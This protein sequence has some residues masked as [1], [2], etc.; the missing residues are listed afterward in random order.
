MIKKIVGI[1]ALVGCS[2]LIQN[3]NA[4]INISADQITFREPTLNTRNTVHYGGLDI[5]GAGTS[6]TGILNVVNQYVGTLS[7]VAVYGYSVPQAGKGTGGKFCGGLYGVNGY[8]SETGAT[9]THYGGYFTASNAPTNYGIYA[10]A[11]NGTKNYAAYFSGNTYCTGSYTPSD[12]KLKENLED[13]DGSLERI[14]K[15]K[16]KKYDYKVKEFQKMNLP[17]GKKFGLLAQD[18]EAIFPEL[19]T[20]M[21][22]PDTSENPDQNKKRE[23]FKAVDYVSLIPILVN[24]IQEQ[25]KQLLEQKKQIAELRAIAKLK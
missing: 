12:E 17:H 25:Q 16:P 8:A 13:I 7:R 14:L 21:S 6:G 4:Q 18:V 22:E 2:L 23:T 9:G 3:A 11:A 1:S 10:S 20:E 15:L 24:A 5:Y 19:I